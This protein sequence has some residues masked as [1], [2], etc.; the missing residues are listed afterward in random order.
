MTRGPLL[1]SVLGGIAGVLLLAV[2]AE[3][4][5]F[6]PP[7]TVTASSQYNADYAVTKL[8]DETVTD[9]D[10]GNTVYGG[11]ST[12][13]AGF[14]AGPFDIFM[15]Y[16]SVLNGVDGLA[17]SQRQGSN[18]DL[19]KVGRIDLWFSNTDFNQTI[20]GTP[21]DISVSISNTA[22]PILTQYTFSGMDFSGQ[23]V[24]ARF[25]ATIGGGGNI[26][27]SEFRLTFNTP[28][29]INPALVIDRDTGNMTLVNNTGSDVNFIAYEIE[30]PSMGGLDASLWTS[31]AA[32]YDADNPGATQVATDSWVEFTAAPFVGVLAEGELPGGSG[33]T[34]SPGGSID[35]GDAW[36]RTSTEDLVVRLI[37]ADGS[38]IT[39]EISYT[40]D[41]VI[42]GDYSGDGSI[43]PEDWAG[44]RSG[45]GNTGD[46]LSPAQAI[47]LGDLD[48]DGDTDL[49]DFRL[50]E[51]IYDANNGAGALAALVS[52]QV[53]EPATTWLLA[54][55]IVPLALIRRKWRRGFCHAITKGPVA[56][57]GLAILLLP[58]ASD[59]RAQTFTLTSP[60]TPLNAAASSEYSDDYAVGNLFD[61][62]TVTAA[63][64]G[65]KV[66][67]LADL[68][69]AGVGVGPMD[70]FLD[71]GSSVSAN[72]ISF[73]QRIGNI[74]TA[75]KVG[76]I[77]L[78]F[79]NSD[80][81]GSVP[82]GAPDVEL[83]ITN[84][85]GLLQPYS[86]G[87]VQSGRYVAARLT[88]ADVS[89]TSGT[90][91]LG[92]NELRLVTGPS[93]VVLQVNRSTGELTIRNQGALAQELQING[94]EIHSNGSLLDT[95][96]GFA[97]GSVAG[98]AGGT[99]SGDGWEKGGLSGE[100]RLVEAYLLGSS[101]LLTD[102]V[103]S[104]GTGYNTSVDAQDLQF[105]VS[106]TS[107]AG[108]FLP[109]RVEY[110]GGST[111]LLG[112]YNDD[113][114]V[115]AAD[116]TV[117][118]NHLGGAAL[119]NE[120]PNASPGVVDQEDYV[121]WK[122]NFG[123]S[124]PGEV[125]L[126][127]TNVPE[128]GS[129]ALV[130]LAAVLLCGSRGGRF[131]KRVI[132]LLAT[133]A[134]P[135][136]LA[137]AGTPDA[138]YLFGDN[139]EYIEN[140]VEGV[141]VGNGGGALVPDFTLDHY[142]DDAVLSTFRDLAPS[143]TNL[144]TRPQYISTAA[145]H[146]PGT[147]LGL[148]VTNN[149]GIHFDGVDDSLHGLG[150]GNPGDGDT[151]FTDN[152]EAAYANLFTRM[153][154]GWV[155][156]EGLTGTRQDI[157]NDTSQFGIHITASDTWGFNYGD[158]DYDTGVDVASTLDAN[159]WAHVQHI[160]NGS[161]AQLLVNGVVQFI[162]PSLGY[163]F[164]ANE[165]IVFGANLDR[166]ANFY[167]GTLDNFRLAV[168]GNNTGLTPNGKNYGP[169]N[170][171]TDNDY[172]AANV[173]PGDANG[174]GLVNGDGTGDEAVDD[175]TYFVN[176]FYATQVLINSVGGEVIMG[177]LN[178]IT[179]L[180]DFNGSGRTDIMDWIILLQNHQDAAAI[181]N[182]NLGALLEARFATVPE[183]A[184]A[185]TLLLAMFG[186]GLVRSQR[187][188]RP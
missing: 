45:L 182:V 13:W 108:L 133:C 74:A 112:D 176:H 124:L 72:Y 159:G 174:D 184:A 1:T 186:W 6:G 30:S 155:R 138:I 40:G 27:G 10:V 28:T 177:D 122:S 161:R 4:D 2:S 19:D 7:V 171:L 136:S 164:T 80:F 39:T 69:Y 158:N 32:N 60:P 64:I 67:G 130:G 93:D 113:G 144:A 162:T 83:E 57:L 101:T 16:G 76:Q 35:L 169:L 49:L 95:W 118:R 147:N 111:V 185:T 123:Q 128:P 66:Y 38:L 85:S 37:A 42:T 21:A 181:A 172:I 119:T 33:A 166:D 58:A 11:G 137:R 183:P 68:Q 163:A 89:L 170:L 153:M 129:L 12:Q 18:P 59:A 148:G 96:K 17:Y 154:D 146:F 173:V 106:V 114:T 98:F 90:N 151:T 8:F 3:A 84:L 160:T 25:F 43:G 103:L 53:P 127:A 116:Y 86:L 168:A 167:K 15:D 24:A 41:A 82:E 156:P 126:A 55:S 102:A 150:L 31:I 107:G 115:D 175:V 188:H 23:Y 140:G 99:G 51:A 134:L 22:N 110:V 34:L 70:I 81:E 92:G 178:S 47:Q 65:T 187:C 180:A 20:P 79:S 135:F 105:Y 78:W 75:D 61:D 121:V 54:G 141:P 29:A 100:S 132:C 149:V 50:F 131:G 143:P 142:G 157:V 97:D 109:G 56:I 77:E 48:G 62:A 139:S 88:I 145:L 125:V 73:A 14:G 165:E 104:L 26:G 63:D 5:V 120:D 91:N 179:T 152:Y 87:G 71:Y 52:T 46:G 9:A 44:F 117:W 94:Y 36:I